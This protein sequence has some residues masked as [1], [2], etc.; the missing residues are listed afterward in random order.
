MLNYS[1]DSFRIFPIKKKS[2][3]RHI[4]FSLIINYYQ[5]HKI[6]FSVFTLQHYNVFVLFIIVVCYI[7]L[8]LGD[9]YV[10]CTKQTE[11]LK[12]LQKSSKMN[13]PNIFIKT[14]AN[15]SFNIRVMPYSDIKPLLD[16]GSPFYT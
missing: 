15:H 8:N 10:E 11:I 3:S 12:V 6:K 16:K 2:Q 7:C 9:S 5:Y 14:L 4:T 13:C 1:N